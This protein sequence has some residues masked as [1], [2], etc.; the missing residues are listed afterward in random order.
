[1]WSFT[2]GVEIDP[3]PERLDDGDHPRL[4]GRSG[5]D[6]KISNK[7]PDRTT[8][9]ISQELAFEL[10]EDPQ[11]LGNR[12][13]DLAVRDIQEECR[14]HPIPPFRQ[15]FGMAGG[16]EAP[17][18][19]GKRQQMFRPAAR[20]TDP[21]EPAAGIAAVEI[22]LDDLLHDRT[23]KAVSTLETRLIFGD[24][25]LKMMKHHTVEDGPL[26]M[27]RTRHSRHNGREASR[28]G[29]T[30]GNRPFPPETRPCRRIGR[31]KSGPKSS[32]AV[33]ARPSPEETQDVQTKALVHIDIDTGMGRTGVPHDKALA[34]IEKIASLASTR[35]E[36]ICTTLTEDPE[37]DR[38]QL[39]RV[40]PPN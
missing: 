2:L 15:A 10:E 26:R 27:S 5:H 13:D 36:G 30:L 28:N 23:E 3:V 11:H 8:A 39:L 33:D 16:T 22:F 24:E 40:S 34:L 25:P 35:I 1:M 21:S 12:E 32:T 38:E 17:G 4:E 31:R 29:P 19:A 9:E 20:A 37:F 6:L 7:R 18:L 14:P